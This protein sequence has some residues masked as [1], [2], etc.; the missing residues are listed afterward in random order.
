M[1]ALKPIRSASAAKQRAHE[2]GGADVTGLAGGLLG[3]QFAAFRCLNISGD[4]A[5]IIHRRIAL[6]R[7]HDG[8]GSRMVAVAIQLDGIAQLP[9][10]ARN[11]P[12]EALHPYQ[13]IR[14]GLQRRGQTGHLRAN[15]LCGIVV[16]REIFLLAGRRIARALRILQQEDALQALYAHW[17]NR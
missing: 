9:Q 2:P 3:A 6:A 11:G 4:L 14:V 13:L 7:R 17:W 5:G 15:L 16:R 8:D 10:L 12:L 1:T